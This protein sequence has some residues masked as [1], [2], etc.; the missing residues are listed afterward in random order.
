V[1]QLLLEGT[2]GEPSTLRLRATV[3]CGG[4]Y[5]TPAPKAGDWF[6]HPGFDHFL[7]MTYLGGPV[8]KGAAYLNAPSEAGRG[9][10]A[11]VSCHFARPG[12]LG[13][14]DC[15]FAPGMQLPSALFAHDLEVEVAGTDGV[16]WLTRGMADR[17]KAAPVSMRVGAR[18][19]T[20][21]VESGLA[22]LW[23]TAYLNAA[24]ELRAWCSGARSL[25]I[26]D[27]Q[28][29]SAYEFK[30]RVVGMATSPGVVSL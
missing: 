10:S 12:L 9:G 7:L 8:A 1:A 29:S 24:E 16:L 20:L 26:S 13:A 19:Y 27:E 28:V 5:P 17:T 4:R 15:T 21:G 2:I 6:A 30:S 22:D 11:L 18:A 3:G 14:L 23:E 25:L